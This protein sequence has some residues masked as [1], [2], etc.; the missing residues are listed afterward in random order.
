MNSSPMTYKE[1][2]EDV[3]RLS[4]TEFKDHVLTEE[5]PKVWRCGRPDSIIFS[6]RV[7]ELPGAIIIWGDLGTMVIDAGKDYTIS[8]LKGAIHSRN[9]VLEKSST[10]RE[11]SFYEGDFRNWILEYTTENGDNPEDETMQAIDEVVGDDYT[12][13]S[14]VALAGKLGDCE[15][16]QMFEGPTPQ[17]DLLCEAL[18]LFVCLLG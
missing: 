4:V 5:H 12:C 11:R 18:Q 6:F 13:E 7:A 17:T 8:W 15:M 1:S 3:R 2:K 10:A 9:Y 16:Y 14:L